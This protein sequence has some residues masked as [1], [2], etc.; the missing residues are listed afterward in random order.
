MNDQMK[1]S[2]SSLTQILPRAIEDQI[3]FV[4]TNCKTEDDINFEHSSLNKLFGFGPERCIDR[5]WFDN[6]ISYLLKFQEQQLQTGK[7]NKKENEKKL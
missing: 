1:Y 6:P 7:T 2:Y 3:M 5:V 4:Y